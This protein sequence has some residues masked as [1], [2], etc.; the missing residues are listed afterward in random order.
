MSIKLDLMVKKHLAPGWDWL[1]WH[2]LGYLHR[3]INPR[4]VSWSWDQSDETQKHHQRHK[5][6]I[7][8]TRANPAS[9]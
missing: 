1:C 3:A 2:T 9:L 8:H 4:R 6:T 5:H 7:S